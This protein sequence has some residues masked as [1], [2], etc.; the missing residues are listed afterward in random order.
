M[1]VIG[2][3]SMRYG[4]QPATMSALMNSVGASW[5]MREL[6]MVV[7]PLMVKARTPSA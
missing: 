7:S 3:S 5:G 1:M 6:V 2:I 4:A